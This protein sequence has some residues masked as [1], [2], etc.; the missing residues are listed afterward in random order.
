MVRGFEEV[1]YPQSDSPTASNNSLKLFFALAA[2]EFM[3][4]KS[5][6]VTSAFL[7]GE[8]LRRKVF[9]EPPA[10][11][12]KCGSIWKLNKSVYGLYDA[13]RK[14]F[15]AVKPQ[16]LSLGM[17]PVSGDEAFFSIV[18]D[19]E[20]IGL[21][22][23]HVDD[24]LVAGKSSFMNALDRT[25][26]GR[27][28]FGKV[29][30]N[31]FKFT[32]LNIQ[33]LENTILVDQIDFINGIKP[34]FS[35]RAGKKDSCEKLNKQEIKLYRGITGQLS[36]A[37][38]NTRPDLAYDV[39][40]LAT[41]TKDATLKDILKANKVLKKAQKEQVRLKYKPIGPWKSLK[42]MTYTDSSYRNDEDSTKS[43]GGRITFLTAGKQR[44]VPLAWK[45][46]T[47]QQVCKS[48]KTAETRSLDNGVEDSVY[49]ARTVNEIF[50][51]KSGK[52]SGQ[53]GVNLKIDSKT[54]L[55]T[56]KSTKQVEEKTVRHIVAWIKQQIEEKKVE[57]VAWVC[58]EEQLAD[59]LTKTGVKTDPI[60]KVL[61][62]GRLPL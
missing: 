56:L 10:E 45:S 38:D 15:Q 9:M 58:A 27:F 26:N 48:V 34:I 55:D 62:A 25:L 7:Q 4:I 60:L 28:K 22:I 40:E 24:F 2:N 29:E 44:C 23:L 31:K 53:I 52:Q 11:R 12:Q 20:L 16:L 19:G 49:L 14:W 43:V 17:K 33:Q 18:K 8:Q 6:D 5:M 46:K 41:R 51:G 57:S 54:L 13:S 50:T 36:W 32:G 37:A 30:T 35:P 21:C 61:K 47:I 39:R 59:V 42:I 1:E 3:K